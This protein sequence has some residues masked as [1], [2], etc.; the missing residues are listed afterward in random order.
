MCAPKNGKSIR[1]KSLCFVEK[2][3]SV[4]KRMTRT[5]VALVDSRDSGFEKEGGTLVSRGV[6]F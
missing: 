1:C 6:R 3:G 2:Y 5:I 4:I